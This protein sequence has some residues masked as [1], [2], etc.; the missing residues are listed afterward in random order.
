MLSSPK[1]ND[2]FS[3]LDM[4][5]LVALSSLTDSPSSP[6]CFLPSHFPFFSLGNSLSV[7][8]RLDSKTHRN[9]L[10]EELGLQVLTT[11]PSLTQLLLSPEKMLLGII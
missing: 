10:V 6:P 8:S 4:T 9:P 11:T 2:T 5:T 7:Y 1:A 3:L